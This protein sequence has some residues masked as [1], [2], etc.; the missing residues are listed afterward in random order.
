MDPGRVDML[1]ECLLEMRPIEASGQ[2]AVV[3]VV[4][5]GID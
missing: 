5:V 4:V 1:Q 3:D 2:M